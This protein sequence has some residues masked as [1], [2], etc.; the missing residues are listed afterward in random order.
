MLRPIFQYAALGGAVLDDMASSPKRLFNFIA[1]GEHKRCR[2]LLGNCPHRPLLWLNTAGYAG[3]TALLEFSGGAVAGLNIA[4]SLTGA[5]VPAMAVTSGLI[6]VFALS[7]FA[8][9]AWR[10][11]Y[12][13]VFADDQDYQESP[14]KAFPRFHEARAAM[15]RN[16]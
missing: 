10:G 6:G 11:L 1:R 2:D 8:I 3:G 5:A 9:M 7:P 15:K 16:P 12:S 4:S 14:V 13:G